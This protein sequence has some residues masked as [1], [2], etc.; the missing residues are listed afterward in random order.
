MLVPAGVLIFFP[1]IVNA[2]VSKVGA[3]FSFS[4]YFLIY[5]FI[6]INIVPA[7]IVEGVLEYW[8]AGVL[9]SSI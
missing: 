9:K 5:D 7:K 6:R 8:S 1:S 4:R 2:M 3:P